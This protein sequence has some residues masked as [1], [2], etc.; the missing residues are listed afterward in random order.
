MLRSV[1]LV[2]I[3]VSGELSPSIIRETRIGELGMLADSCH[4][5]D[6]GA[7]YLRNSVLTRATLRNIPEDAVLYSH[8]RENLKSYIISNIFYRFPIGQVI[9]LVL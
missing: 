7:K 9:F 3:D 1:A 5:D 6:G 8:R 2:R 4:P